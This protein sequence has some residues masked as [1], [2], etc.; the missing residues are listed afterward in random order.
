VR[1]YTL[2]QSITLASRYTL[3]IW[4]PNCPNCQRSIPAVIREMCWGPYSRSGRDTT[5]PCSCILEEFSV[6]TIAQALL[7][8]CSLERR[9]S[10]RWFPNGYLVTTS[11]QSPPTPW[12]DP[13]LAG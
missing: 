2:A 10:N 3:Q 9:W 6:F 4:F 8:G 12:T 5:L 7:P 1:P 13:S 11:S